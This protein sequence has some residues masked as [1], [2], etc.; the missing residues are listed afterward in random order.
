MSDAYVIEVADETV[1]IVVRQ[2]SERAFRFHA[3]LPR[4]YSLDGHIFNA[5]RDAERAVIAHLG[6]K[7]KGVV[8]TTQ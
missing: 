5:P 6:R 4:Y 7:R 2:A 8:E 1:G 3:A